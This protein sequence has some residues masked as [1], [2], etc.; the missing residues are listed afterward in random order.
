MK[1]SAGG[2]S[3]TIIA[4]CVHALQKDPG[5]ILYLIGSD[6]EARKISAV[7][8]R[9]FLRQVFGSDVVD[10]KNQ[11]ALHLKING[12]EIFIGSPTEE[13]LR[14]KQIQILV[15]DESDTLPEIL[16]GGAQDL[17]TAEEERTKNARNSKIIRLCC[18][19]HQHDPAA[20]KDTAQPQAR[21]HR[22]YLRGDQ[23]EFRCPCPACGIEHPISEHN[24]ITDHCR[25]LAGDLDLDRV[26][27][28][29]FWRCPSCAHEI[30]DTIQAKTPFFNA[31]RHVPT[32]RP[33]SR[34]VWSALVT[35][36]AVLFGKASSW[37]FVMSSL[38]GAARE[39]ESK[40]AA[41]RRSHLAEPRAREKEGS[42]RTIE[43]LKKHCSHYPRG[44][45]P[46]IPWVIGLAA[47]VQKDASYFPWVSAA[48]NRRGDLFVLDWGEARDTDEL[49]VI[50]R[51]PIPTHV[52]PTPEILTKYPDGTTPPVFITHA[53]IDSGHRAKGDEV[54]RTATTVYNFVHRAGMSRHQD[55]SGTSYRYRWV[56]MKGRGANQLDTLIQ[57]SAARL[58]DSIHLPLVLFRDPDFKADLYH[59]Q[60]AFDP[61]PDAP[62]SPTQQ[63]ARTLP[64]ILFPRYLTDATLTESQTPYDDF[65]AELQSERYGSIMHHPRTGGPSYE[66][67]RWYVPAGLR[68]NFGDCIKM[69]KVLHANL[70][71]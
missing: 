19:L 50:R 65:L 4:A 36:L 43:S 52:S 40:A 38:L 20:T 3:T 10:A 70:P 49:E 17:D 32:A 51:R 66:I 67:R 46:V 24:L 26:A 54:D 47:D 34:R 22:H 30:P 29:T 8:W 69:L 58:T 56:P 15:E 63:Q 41:A 39:G 13:Q 61:T 68:N 55:S 48:F 25:D 53:V 57:T 23:R 59:I 2:I 18:P 64:R 33:V 1:S 21:I 31:G 45:C 71:Q 42:T 14:S 27:E 60:L 44:I 6:S 62:D 28:E 7:Y 9:P 16:K 5:N 11:A 35:D 37:G 12:V